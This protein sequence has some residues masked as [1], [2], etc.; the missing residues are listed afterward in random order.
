AEVNCEVDPATPIF[1]AVDDHPL[2]SSWLLFYLGDRSRLLHNLTFLR[3]DRIKQAEVY[4]ICRQRDE[5]TL[6]EYGVA[7]RLVQSGHARGE[8][9]PHDRWTLY[10]LRF[11]PHL[12]R[13]SGDVRISPLQATGRRPGPFL[14]RSV[15]IGIAASAAR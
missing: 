12:A 7:E 4:L 3:D 9:S 11:Y 8:A 15:A 10:K 14:G 2:N 5:A 1:V 13:V 6:A